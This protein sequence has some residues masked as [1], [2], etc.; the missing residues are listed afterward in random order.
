VGGSRS[1]RSLRGTT[2]RLGA[3]DIRCNEREQNKSAGS[4][5]ESQPASRV[6]QKRANR[7]TFATKNFHSTTCK[8]D[9]K[10]QDRFLTDC[11][12]WAPAKS[13]QI[14]AILA[15]ICS[16]TNKFNFELVAARIG[17]SAATYDTS[18]SRLRAVVG[19]WRFDVRKCGSA[20]E[21]PEF[22]P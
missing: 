17:G 11:G 8:T 16:P 18:G 2:I 12:N 1:G 5:A 13:R 15:A 6:A 10:G 4:N 9:W 7:C 3:S 14:S 20:C 19:A 22:S 21:S